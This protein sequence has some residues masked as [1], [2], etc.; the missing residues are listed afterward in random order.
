MG[1]FFVGLVFFMID[2]VEKKFLFKM[3]GQG[4]NIFLFWCIGNGLW[5]YLVEGID[6]FLSSFLLLNFLYNREYR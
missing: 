1:N 5:F 6:Q 3:K 4:V 2:R